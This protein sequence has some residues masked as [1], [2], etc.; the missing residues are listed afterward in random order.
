[1]LSECSR[2]CDFNIIFTYVW[3]GWGGVAY[4]SRVLKEVAF[5]QDPG[6]PF[7]PPSM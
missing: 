5:D 2:I 3:A 1:M 7:L 4:D 6:V